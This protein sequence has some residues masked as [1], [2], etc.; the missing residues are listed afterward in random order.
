[1]LG[2]RLREDH[3]LDRRLEVLQ[4]EDGHQVALL[5]PLALQA[6]DH[7]ADDAHRAVLDLGEVGDGAVGP[8]AQRRLGAHQR[9]V[10][11]VEAEHLLLEREPLASC[12][13]RG[14]G[15]AAA[16]RTPAPPSLELAEQRHHAHVALAAAGEGVVDDLLEHGEQALAGVAERV[17]A[18]GLDERLDASAC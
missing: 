2:H 18:A 10:A 13:T 7:A 17:E 14:R 16:R 5:G 8:A 15:S 3:H 11:H 12:R 1:M 6:G 9:V 4:D